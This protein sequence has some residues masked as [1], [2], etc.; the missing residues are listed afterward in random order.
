[1]GR[2]AYSDDLRALVVGEVTGGTSRRSAARRF[3]VSASSAI[4]WVERHA[5]T[6]SVSARKTPKPRSP[7]E[8]H[9]S[10]LLELIAKEPDLTLA[11]IVQR[12]GSDLGMRSSD[13]AIDRFF[14]RHKISFKKKSLHA[15]EQD[16][17][18]VAEAR[19]SF[20]AN[21]PGLD[22]KRLVFVD[23]TGTSTKMVRSRGRCTRGQRLVAK[24]PWGHWKTT[25][26]TAGL[27]CDRLVAPFVLD[28]PMNG[29]A[30]LTYV[31]TVLTPGLSPGDVVVIDNLTAH[32]VAGVRTLIEAKGASLLYLPPY[33]PDFNP[34]EMVFAKLKALLHEAAERAPQAPSGTGSLNSSQPSH[35]RNAQTTSLMP[36]MPQNKREML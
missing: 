18:D 36:D 14:K 7:L 29:E 28:G 12:L 19:Q 17:P 13:S 11:E 4:R 5:E 27:R 8:P 15:A 21:Q 34:I 20:K 2:R 32:K 9:A 24:A 10:W 23:E 33:S 26:F 25:T 30:F 3:K 22:P 16:R 31:E 6:G 1:M 35:P